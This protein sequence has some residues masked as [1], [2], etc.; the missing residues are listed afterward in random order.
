MSEPFQCDKCS[1]CCRLVFFV[2]DQAKENPDSDDELVKLINEFPYELNKDGSCSMLGEDG[3]CSVYDER[4][5]I[6][7]VDDI[8]ERFYAKIMSKEQ[9]NTVTHQA[10]DH[11]KLV[12]INGVEEN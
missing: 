7:R 10:C 6:C 11:L 2:I 5:I 9:F 1:A 12:I 3:L 8:Y 4:P